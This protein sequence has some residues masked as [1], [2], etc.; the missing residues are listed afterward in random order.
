MTIWIRELADIPTVTSAIQ[1]GYLELQL[2]QPYG[3]A[4]WSYTCQKK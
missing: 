1:L 3:S 4:T 2:R